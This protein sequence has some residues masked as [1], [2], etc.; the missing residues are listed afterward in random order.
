MNSTYRHK[1]TDAT[2]TWIL[3]IILLITCLS[4]FFSHMPEKPEVFEKTKKIEIEVV[5]GRADYKSLD[6]LLSINPE[7]LKR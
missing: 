7:D 5:C 3:V 2:V 6:C 1:P 4:I